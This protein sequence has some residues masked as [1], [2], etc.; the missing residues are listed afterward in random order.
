MEGSMICISNT[1]FATCTLQADMTFLFSPVLNCGPNNRCIEN[2]NNTTTCVGPTPP[3]PTPPNCVSDSSVQSRNATSVCCNNLCCSK[4]GFCGSTSDFCGAGCQSGPCTM[5]PIP[6]TPANCVSALLFVATTCVAANLAFV[7]VPTIIVELAGCQ[8]G[9]RTGAP[10][11]PA[12]TP[13]NCVSDSSVQSCNVSSV[14]CNT[15]VADLVFVEA[16]AIIVDQAANLD[17]VLKPST[18][19][20][21]S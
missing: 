21:L 8:S 3:T 5:P 4:F 16:P 2:D 10:T 19:L 20:A 7:E 13:A 17:L 6:P 11:P 15:S 12:P 1:L 9:P 14:C 18:S